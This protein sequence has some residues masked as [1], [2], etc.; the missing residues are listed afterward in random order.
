VKAEQEAA[1]QEAARVKAEQEAAEQEAARVKAEEEAARVK[2]EQEAAELEAAEQEAAEQEA[3]RVKAEQE[4][5]R[6][7]AEQEAAEQEAARVKA[8][9]EAAE[10]EAARVKAEQEAAEVE[11][12]RAKA[13]VEA[14]RVKAEQEAAIS[15][16]EDLMSDLVTQ[17]EN[18]VDEEKKQVVEIKRIQNAMYILAMVTAAKQGW[19][20]HQG[21]ILKTKRYCVLS[22]GVLC[23][24]ARPLDVSPY[25]QDLKVEVVLNNHVLKEL[26]DSRF[27]V[28]TIEGNVEHVPQVGLLRRLSTRRRSSTTIGVEESIV[29]EASSDKEADDWL[30]IMNIQMNH[31]HGAALDEKQ[32]LVQNIYLKGCLELK[33]FFWRPIYAVLMWNRIGE[34]MQ[35]AS[36]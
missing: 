18:R 24:Y 10:Q 17:T 11:A 7:K 21:S 9:Q 35:C 19:L 34:L 33:G 4:A 23:L 6:V 8:E 36:V 27:E 5:A 13:E 2:A 28:Q 22:K 20:A 15:T 31:F 32:D 25:G 16:L 12:A 29:L 26:S 1:E 14:A 3:A 30:T